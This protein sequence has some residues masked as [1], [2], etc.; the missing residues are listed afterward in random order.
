MRKERVILEHEAD[1]AAIGRY[2]SDVL[3]AEMPR[4]V[5]CRYLEQDRLL[6]G[7]WRDALDAVVS[8]PPPPE[9]P[10]TNGADVIA[11]MIAERLMS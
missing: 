9:Q 6:A 1:A 3:V 8:A 10:P 11:S 4:F 5:R 7:R 2:A